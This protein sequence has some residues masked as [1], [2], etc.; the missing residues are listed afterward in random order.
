MKP[1]FLDCPLRYTRTPREQT[2]DVRYACALERIDR[3]MDWQ[4][5][6]VIGGC[7]VA[8]VALVVILVLT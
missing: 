2:D 7:I 8:A 4:D 3:P 5:K 6:V 1:N